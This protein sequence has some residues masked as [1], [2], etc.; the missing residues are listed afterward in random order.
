MTKNDRFRYLCA[1]GFLLL[2]INTI[3]CNYENQNIF[4]TS[5]ISYYNTLSKNPLIYSCSVE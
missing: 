4:S 1:K 3:K 5:K 2:D